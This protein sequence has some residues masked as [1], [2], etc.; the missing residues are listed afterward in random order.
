MQIMFYKFLAK[1]EFKIVKYLKNKGY[2][3]DIITELDSEFW[4][5]Y[6]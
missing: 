3:D 1:I 5:D 4:G 2:Y 6:E